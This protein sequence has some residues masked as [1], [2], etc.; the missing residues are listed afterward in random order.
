MIRNTGRLRTGETTTRQA[1]Y[2]RAYDRG[3]YDIWQKT[4]GPDW[5]PPWLAR[6]PHGTEL[7]ATTIT[8]I[9]NSI[10]AV[11][12]RACHECPN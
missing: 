2:A 6:C 11:L 4:S 3:T 5:A 10:A 12:R 8:E 9:R 7:P 1:T